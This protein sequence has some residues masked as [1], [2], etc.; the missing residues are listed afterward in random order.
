MIE[1]KFLIESI[2]ISSVG[3][4]HF[5]PFFLRSTRSKTCLGLLAATIEI[6]GLAG[7]HEEVGC[8]RKNKFAEIRRVMQSILRFTLQTMNGLF[9][10]QPIARGPAKRR[11]HAAEQRACVDAAFIAERYHG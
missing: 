1:G 3:D 10:F 6:P 8:A 5:V 4:N 7:L 11:I 2:Q 9:D